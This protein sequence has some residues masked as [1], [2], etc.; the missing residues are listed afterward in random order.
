MYFD[1]LGVGGSGGVNRVAS[2]WRH[3]AIL[4]HLESCQVGNWWLLLPIFTRFGFCWLGLMANIRLLLCASVFAQE[5][6]MKRQQQVLE[7]EHERERR[8]QH[9]VLAKALEQ[10]KKHEEKQVLVIMQ[11][12]SCHYWQ[13]L[14]LKPVAGMLCEK[15]VVP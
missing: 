8:R 4:S 14:V 3:L 13:V 10:R 7:R 1:D 9:L 5:R 15:T 12:L 11:V 6:G 2:G